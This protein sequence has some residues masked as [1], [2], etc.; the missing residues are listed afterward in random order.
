M[1]P[2]LSL[3]L[4]IDKITLPKFLVTWFLSGPLLTIIHLKIP[5]SDST[6]WVVDPYMGS[7]DLEIG[8]WVPNY[9]YHTVLD[10]HR[11]PESFVSSY[12]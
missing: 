11:Q 2:T 6:T 7:L 4:F 3:S 10:L 12:N 1:N 9:C 8:P 5:V